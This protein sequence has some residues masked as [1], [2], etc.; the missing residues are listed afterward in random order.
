ML[1]TVEYQF[2][3]VQAAGRAVCPFCQS[4]HMRSNGESIT[5]SCDGRYRRNRRV[6]IVARGRPASLGSGVRVP[7][8]AEMQ[9]AMVHAENIVNS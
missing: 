3:V 6:A 8:E 9:A 5:E 7:T 1:P 4:W 2:V